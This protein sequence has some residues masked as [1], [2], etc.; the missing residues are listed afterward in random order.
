MHA[1]GVRWFQRLCT[2]QPLHAKRVVSR[3]IESYL[4]WQLPLE[5]YE[6]K[7]D[8]PFEED[9]GSC[10]MAI[11]PEN[12]FS[13]A[14][15]GRIRFK[16]TSK[17]WFF[18]NGLEFDDGS[19]LEADVVIL[20]TGYDGKNKLKDIMPQPFRS[21]IEGISGV[22]PL[23]RSTINPMIPN[24][25]FVGYVETVSNLQAAEL[26]CKWLA[27]LAADAFKLPSNNEM[28]DQIAKEVEVMRKT[29]RFYK[30]HCISTFSID[31]NDKLCEDMGWRSW[32]KHNWL[33]EAFSPYTSQ[34]Y[35]EKS[36]TK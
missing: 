19:K 7:P 3:I 35:K 25:A 31:H 26:R 14:D 8:H 18:E 11:L 32:R 34:D 30:R 29:T 24:M 36:L 33:S 20:A 23:Y 5:K 16:K 9:Y 27:G 15:Q 6:L 12:F 1:H 21:F 28:L 2:E 17:W 10:Q 22:T 13:E 4:L